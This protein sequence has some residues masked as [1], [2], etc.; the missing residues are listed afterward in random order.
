[1]SKRKRKPSRHRDREPSSALLVC[2]LIGQARRV[3]PGTESADCLNCHRPVWVSRWA[4]GLCRRTRTEPVFLCDP[5][6]RALA[7]HLRHRRGLIP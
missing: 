4:R 3:P 1:M 2:T 5:C 6:A 7:D